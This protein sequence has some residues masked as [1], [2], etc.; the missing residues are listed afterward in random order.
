MPLVLPD[1]DD[2]KPVMATLRKFVKFASKP[3]IATPPPPPPKPVGKR[4]VKRVASNPGVKSDDVPKAD[5]LYK[6]AGG[7]ACLIMFFSDDRQTFVHT[8]WD[9]CRAIG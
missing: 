2:D 5:K 1:S 3:A 6:V 7:F 9:A 4:G 8:H